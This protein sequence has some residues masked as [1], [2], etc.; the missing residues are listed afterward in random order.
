MKLRF[1]MKEREGGWGR[2]RNIAT[3][4]KIMLRQQQ[5]WHRT[6]RKWLFF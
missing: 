4:H 6:L 2:E 1:Q 3:R 5:F